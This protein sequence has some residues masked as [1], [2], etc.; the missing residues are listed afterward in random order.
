MC[1]AHD[2]GGYAGVEALKAVLVKEDIKDQEVC[3][4][5]QLKEC[6]LPSITRPYNFF[7]F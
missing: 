5:G 4:G 3:V 7:F 6:A 2:S 1:R